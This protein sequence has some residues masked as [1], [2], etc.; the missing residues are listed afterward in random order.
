MIGARIV[1]AV[2]F[3]AC[4]DVAVLVGL[5]AITPMGRRRRHVMALPS[6]L[7]AIVG[8]VILPVW[9]LDTVLNIRAAGVVP[10]GMLMRLGV[11]CAAAETRDHAHSQEGHL[12]SALHARPFRIFP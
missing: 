11:Y 4:L 12:C 9:R 5:T 3:P 2:A 7:A 10:G 6:C 1:G 8:S